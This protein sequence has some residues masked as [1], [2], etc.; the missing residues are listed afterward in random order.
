MHGSREY[1]TKSRRS[2]HPATPTSHEVAKIPELYSVD[3]AASVQD[4][5]IEDPDPDRFKAIMAELAETKKALAEKDEALAEK[6][7]ALAEK[8][9]ALTKTKKE[10]DIVK[11]SYSRGKEHRTKLSE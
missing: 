2:A 7:E 9:E 3:L 8:D 5:R 11:A 1:S 4:L 6:D 10:L